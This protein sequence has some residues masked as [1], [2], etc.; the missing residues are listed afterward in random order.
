MP[1]DDVFISNWNCNGPSCTPHEVVRRQSEAV[2]S[3]KRHYGSWYRDLAGLLGE[4]QSV[5]P[6]AAELRNSKSVSLSGTLMNSAHM[7]PHVVKPTEDP[8]AIPFTRNMPRAF[9]LR[10]VRCLVSCA[11]FRSCE[12][13]PIVL[14]LAPGLAA[15]VGPTVML[16]AFSGSI[17]PIRCRRDRASGIGI[18]GR[19]SMTPWLMKCVVVPEQYW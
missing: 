12:A 16:V 17:A 8:R 13:S 3:V 6:C 11:V 19:A 14:S 9:Y 1:N 7:I 10:V 15:M 2:R 4:A 18:C 5:A